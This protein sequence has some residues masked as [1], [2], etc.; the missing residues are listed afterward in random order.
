MSKFILTLIALLTC[1]VAN[2]VTIQ[3]PQATGTT[4]IGEAV[5]DR[6]SPITN[7]GDVNGDN[8][9]DLLMSA[10]NSPGGGVAYLVYGQSVMP[11]TVYLSQVGVSVPGVKFKAVS[12]TGRTIAAAGDLNYDGL[13]DFIIGVG[14]WSHS[15]GFYVVYGSRTFPANVDLRT[16]GYIN[17]LLYTNVLPGKI[18]VGDINQDGISDIVVDSQFNN[19]VTILYGAT[20]PR[21]GYINLNLSTLYDGIVATKIITTN[22]I[23]YAYPSLADVNRD[24]S[25]DIIYYAENQAYILFGKAGSFGPQIIATESYFNGINGSRLFTSQGLFTTAAPIDDVNADGIVDIGLS[26]SKSAI[27]FGRSVWP[28]S[29]NIDLLDGTNGSL[30]TNGIFTNVFSAGDFDNDNIKDVAFGLSSGNGYFV[31]ISGRKTW[32][33]SYAISALDSSVLGENLGLNMAGQESAENLNGANACPRTLSL[34]LG[35]QGD[36]YK[37]GRTYIVNVTR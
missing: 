37:V 15:S 31:I 21:V 18:S 32:P 14:S 16:T 35:A 36:N 3:L 24:G 1:G 33:A 20:R 17:G 29:L 2:A 11:T 19:S 4:F 12:F 5:N 27:V 7:L 10:Y 22:S 8:I 6:L 25:K 9:P 34:L 26:N 13:N 30:I 23:G 28:A